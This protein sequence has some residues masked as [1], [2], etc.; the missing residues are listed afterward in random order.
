MSFS[1]SGFLSFTLP[2]KAA[3]KL[4]NVIS[5]LLSPLE[6]NGT[7]E[8]MPP[9]L[10]QP[11]R[12]PQ[13]FQKLSKPFA[14]NFI[15]AKH[16][17]RRRIFLLKNVWVNGE[18]VVFKNL[19]VF[20]PSLPWPEDYPQ[21]QKG[22]F[23]IQQWTGKVIHHKHENEA[24]LIYDR[25]ATENYYHWMIE[26]LPRLLLAQRQFPDCAVLVPV[27]A[28]EFVS[29]S[30]EM[31]EVKRIVFNTRGGTIKVDNL[32]VPERVYYYEEDEEMPMAYLHTEYE[33]SNLKKRVSPDLKPSD[34]SKE[35]L[36]VDVRK[37][38]LQALPDLS[39]K[40]G[41]KIFASRANQKTRRLINEN[42]IYP[43]LEQWGFEVVFFDLLSFTEQVELMQQT[44]LL[45]GVHGANLVN[46]LFLPPT[47]K[48][49]ELMNEH[50]FNE[51]YY[52]LSSSLD[53]AYYSVPCAM[54]DASLRE[55]GS[56]TALNDADLIADV[57]RLAEAIQ[58]CMQ[59]D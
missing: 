8:V 53:I 30:L 4:I 41:R 39:T 28:P 36:I 45:M 48:V 42:D 21:Y 14:N 57:R 54:A 19:K 33:T 38:F 24:A 22:H 13:N 2:V 49:I 25:W 34:L 29:T 12:Q 1:F 58:D 27:P 5:P 3:C 20:L 37:K 35:E 17:P 31:M 43:L 47:A 15:R 40:P 32:I 23:L 7:V 9:L 10:W 59:G 6:S 18:G 26:A 11:V 56:K 50:H 44:S 55:D 52:L 16:I 46:I 51:A